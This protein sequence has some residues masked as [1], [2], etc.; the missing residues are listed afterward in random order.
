MRA[1]ATLVATALVVAGIATGASADTSVRYSRLSPFVAKRVT[2][3]GV[4]AHLRELANES[5][6]GR[7]TGSADELRA[8]QYIADKLR[9]AGVAPAGEHGSYFQKVPL[10]AVTPTAPGVLTFAGEAASAELA[11]GTDYAGSTQR[12]LQSPAEITV[13]GEPGHAPLGVVDAQSLDGR[14]LL[15]RLGS[16]HAR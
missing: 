8:A 15:G 16:G 4:R 14:R 13:A 9:R 6:R 10:T 7:M 1:L 5:Y 11:W 3:D 2:E 12:P